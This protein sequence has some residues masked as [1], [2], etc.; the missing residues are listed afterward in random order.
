V[1]IPVIVTIRLGRAVAQS[2][3]DDDASACRRGQGLNDVLGRL[4]VDGASGGVPDLA[5][6]R[7]ELRVDF[8]LAR[9]RYRPRRDSTQVEILLEQF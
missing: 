8:R 4:E 2:P 5:C 3:P 7:L 6:H 1:P 9:R